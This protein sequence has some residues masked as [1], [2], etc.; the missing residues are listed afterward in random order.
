MNPE[1]AQQMKDT[2]NALGPLLRCVLKNHPAFAANP[3]GDWKE[4][5]GEQIARYSQP[6][7]LKNK[8]LTVIVHDSVWKHHLDLLRDAL[9]EKI[10]ARRPEPIVTQ[11]VL[12]VGEVPPTEPVLNPQFHQLEKLKKAPTSKIG[13]QKLPRR[14][15]T[16]EESALIASL[17][18]AELRRIAKRLLEKVAVEESG[19]V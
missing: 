5:V 15:L 17:P 2:E 13:R 14:K 19:E 8:I 3:I 10:N 6:K 11:I 4:L 16:S 1:S 7:S 18:D 12:R 9:M